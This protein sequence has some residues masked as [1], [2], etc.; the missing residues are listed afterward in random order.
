MPEARELQAQGLRAYILGK[1]CEAEKPSVCLHFL[2]KCISTVAASIEAQNESYIFWYQEVCF[3][4]F[5]T[6]LV[7]RLW[8]FECLSVEDFG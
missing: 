3:K 7:S 2:V 8:H 6:A 5:L 1:S 4:K